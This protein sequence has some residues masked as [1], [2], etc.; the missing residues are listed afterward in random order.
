M[1]PW[2]M[3]PKIEYDFAFRDA[4]IADKFVRTDRPQREK[5]A[6]DPRLA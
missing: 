5:A 1:K 2:S 6:L 3:G 4:P